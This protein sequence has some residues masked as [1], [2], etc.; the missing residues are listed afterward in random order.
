MIRPVG[1]VGGNQ[2]MTV[3]V[4]IA[5][6]ATAAI[7]VGLAASIASLLATLGHP[8][9]ATSVERI[10]AL[11]AAVPFLVVGVVGL[12]LCSVPVAD[13]WR[14][15]LTLAWALLVASLCLAGPLAGPYGTVFEHATGLSA[16]SWQ[17]SWTTIPAWPGA[18]PH[19]VDLGL[20]R[21]PILV[22]ATVAAGLVGMQ[23]ASV[24]RL[25]ERLT[26][27]ARHLHVRL[28]HAT[29]GATS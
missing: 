2:G 10:G 24:A 13:R 3:R 14:G 1:T 8:L 26:A 21:W 18:W 11:F 28:R 27:S 29:H 25:S 6:S 4:A 12:A 22:G 9:S 17:A 20:A 7:L 15:P 19:L 5:A 16:A 23:L